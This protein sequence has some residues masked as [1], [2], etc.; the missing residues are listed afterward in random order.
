MR[1]GD[2]VH[3]IGID[4]AWGDKQPTGLAVIDDGARLLHVSA[5][6]TDEIEVNDGGVFRR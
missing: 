1:Q 2:R 5:V 3:Y 4:L 6:R